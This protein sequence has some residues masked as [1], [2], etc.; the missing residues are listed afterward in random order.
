[1]FIHSANRK[2][3]LGDRQHKH[4]W[5]VPTLLSNLDFSVLLVSSEQKEH[6]WCLQ[7][8]QGYFLQWYIKIRGW[9]EKCQLWK[10]HW[11]QLKQKREW[12]I[13]EPPDLEQEHTETYRTFLG[14]FQN[15]GNGKRAWRGRWDEVLDAYL[16]SQCLQLWSVRCNKGENAVNSSSNATIALHWWRGHRMLAAQALVWDLDGHLLKDSV[17]LTV[18]YLTVKSVGVEIKLAILEKLIRELQAS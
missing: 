14:S 9:T 5:T 7:I 8:F 13:Q 16:F 18:S 1:M 3:E 15:T 2:V 12:R 4:C 17:T 6:W 11:R 10:D